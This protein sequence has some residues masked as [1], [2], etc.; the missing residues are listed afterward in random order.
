MV[1]LTEMRQIEQNETTCKACALLCSPQKDTAILP[2]NTHHV[3]P[4]IN[5]WESKKMRGPLKVLLISL[6]CFAVPPST[7]SC[8]LWHLQNGDRHKTLPLSTNRYWIYCRKYLAKPKYDPMPHLLF[9]VFWSLL[10]LLPPGTVEL[11]NTLESKDVWIVFLLEQLA[12]IEMHLLSWTLRS[13][14]PF[15]CSIFHFC[16]FF[17]PN[18]IFSLFS[19]LAFLSL[20]IFFP[21]LPSLILLLITHL[22]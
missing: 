14:L 11:E 17:I 13:T 18:F 7:I 8:C 10:A 15:S 16:L 12:F 21:P 19:S 22:I 2:N 1:R 20:Y 4:T 6:Y 9:P 5:V 3:C